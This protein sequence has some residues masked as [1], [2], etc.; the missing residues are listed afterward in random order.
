MLRARQGERGG[1]SLLRERGA[2]WHGTLTVLYS[3][4]RSSLGR[5][6]R[7][8]K[9]ELSLTQLCLQPAWLQNLTTRILLWAAFNNKRT[10]F[11]MIQTPPKK[12]A[13]GLDS[14]S[15]GI[16]KR[17]SPIGWTRPATA[18]SRTST[19]V[20]FTASR[21]LGST[22]SEYKEK[23]GCVR[24]VTSL[25]RRVLPGLF[26]CHAVLLRAAPQRR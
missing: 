23:F 21:A 5:N 10:P 18:G 8:Y 16:T 17:V 20:D 7:R 19:S 4:C 2:C 9:P 6:R 3:M 26:A 22:L 25:A 13:A 15:I 1:A 24:H 11:T 14:L 12:P